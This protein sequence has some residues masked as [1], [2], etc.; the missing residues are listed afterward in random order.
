MSEEDSQAKEEF[1]IPAYIHAD[2]EV[3]E[4]PMPEIRVAVQAQTDLH[5]A[6]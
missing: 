2:E 6:E 4:S 5:V 1:A 3:T